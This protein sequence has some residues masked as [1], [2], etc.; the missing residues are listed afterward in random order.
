MEMNN[1]M[2]NYHLNLLLSKL[3]FKFKTKKTNVRSF[4]LIEQVKVYLADTDNES[5]L[6]VGGDMRKI[7]QCYR[8]FKVRIDF[9]KFL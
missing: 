7:D 5:T 6:D 2:N 1:L 9:L 8:A 4:R 3:N